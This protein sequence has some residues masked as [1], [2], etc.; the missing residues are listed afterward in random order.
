MTWV[1][2]WRCIEAET[3]AVAGPL[4]GVT[5]QVLHKDALGVVVE[6][7]SPEDLEEHMEANPTH[8]VQAVWDYEAD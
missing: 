1:Q 3:T 7:D 6:F 8:R 4:A 2:K 5:A